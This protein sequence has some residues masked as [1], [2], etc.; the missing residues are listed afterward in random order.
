MS[1]NVDDTIDNAI[2]R[3]LNGIGHAPQPVETAAWGRSVGGNSNIRLHPDDVVTYYP[4]GNIA[5]VMHNKVG[6]RTITQY[7]ETGRVTISQ[8]LNKNDVVNFTDGY[9]SS[10]IKYETKSDHDTQ[11]IGKTTL[12]YGPGGKILS[13]VHESKIDIGD[14]LLENSNMWVTTSKTTYNDNGTIAAH[15]TYKQRKN[16][17][18][19]DSY[20]ASIEQMDESGKITLS[21]QLQE[22]DQVNYHP[23]GRVASILRANKEGH[24]QSMTSYDE[25]GKIMNQ[26]VYQDGKVISSIDYTDGKPTHN[27]QQGDET[28]QNIFEQAGKKVKDKAKQT[29]DTPVQLPAKEHD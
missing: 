28:Y 10:I 19:V 12:Q 15:T 26:T 7:D 20:I 16:G 27:V 23:T 9:I 13:S 1:T 5:T 22:Q 29:S 11:I 24:P 21:V 25:N 8:A 4:D 3:M 18:K 6:G 2:E 17:Q 14:Y